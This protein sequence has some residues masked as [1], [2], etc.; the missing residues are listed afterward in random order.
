M[1]AQMAEQ[2]I[3]ATWKI[4]GFGGAGYDYYV[5]H[6]GTNFGY[7][8]GSEVTA[9]Y[10]YASPI[11][12]AGQLRKVYFPMKRAAMF[13]QAFSDVLTSSKDGGTLVASNT[14]NVQTFARTSANGTAI[15]LADAARFQGNGRG[16]GGQAAP[17]PQAIQTQIILADGRQIP[18]GTNT[19]T[20]TPGEI[21]PI[22]TDIVVQRIP[23]RS[24]S[25][26]SP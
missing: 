20:L 15:F 5:V 9:S 25:A 24:R 6:G 26:P 8:K 2:K 18:S 10:D 3:R 23:T 22:L 12:E 14:A 19:L 4:L 17:V 13:A 7:S 21:R 11:G 1:S 16:R